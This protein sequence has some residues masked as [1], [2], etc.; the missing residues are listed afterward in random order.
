MSDIHPASHID[1]SAQIGPGVRVG[2]GAFVGPRCVLGDGCVLHPGAYV[3]RDSTLGARVEVY[4]GAVIGGPPQDLK[5]DES[6]PASCEVG[7][8][9]VIRESAT[10]NLGTLD[11]MATRVGAHCMLMEGAHVGHNARV[12]DRTILANAAKLGG[13]TTVGERCFISAHTAVHQFTD[14]GDGCMFQALACVS[15]HVPPFVIVA[16]GANAGAVGLNR[17][18]LKRSGLY[19]RD[20][21]DQIKACYKA[22]YRGRE[23]GWSSEGALAEMNGVATLPGA[24]AFVGFIERSL[25]QGAPRAR[26]VIGPGR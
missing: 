7:E 20:D 3:L 15:M 14:V 9:T 13:H 22:Y 24:R 10:V 1:S 21:L 4:P 23:S 19:S 2:P 6:Q 17:V 26:G 25:A 18:G 8:G 12:G 16:S 11:P 5:F